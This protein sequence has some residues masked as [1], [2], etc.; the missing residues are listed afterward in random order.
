MH[1]IV[2][3]PAVVSAVSPPEPENACFSVTLAGVHSY[4]PRPFF[5][6]FTHWL[7]AYTPLPTPTFRQRPISGSARGSYSAADALV[8]A[9]ASSARTARRQLCPTLVTFMSASISL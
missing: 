7:P 8:A 1:L 2:G 5:S 3:W 9:K 6:T 4:A